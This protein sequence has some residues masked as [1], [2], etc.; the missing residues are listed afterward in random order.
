MSVAKKYLSIQP[1]NVPASGKVSFARGNPI[2]T[3]TLGRQDGVLDLSSLRL[4]GDLNIWRNAAGTLP[5]TGASAADGDQLR[6]SHKLGIYG[7]IDQLVFRHAETKQLLEHIRHYG[8]FMSSYLPVMAGMQDVAGHLSKTALIYPNYQSFRDAVIRRPDDATTTPNEFCIHLPSGL[9]LGESSIPLSKIPLEIEIHLVPDS[10]FFYSS[11]GNTGNIANCF[12]ELS[13]LEVNCEVTYG[14]QTPDKGLLSFNS[15][16]SYFSTIETTNSIINFN[17][18][19]KNVLGAFV[20]FVPSSFINNL[21]QDGYLT[22]MP[23]LAPNAAGTGD[24][25]VANLETISFLRNGERFPS[26]FEV[27]SVRS[28]SNETPVVD[29]QVIKNFLSAIIPEKMH[30]RTTASPLNTNRNYTVNNNADTGY[31]FMPD[32]GALYGVGQ[33]YDQL[34]SQGVDFSNS[35]FSI[36]MINGLNDGNPIS[37]YLFIKSKVVVAWDAQMGIQVIQ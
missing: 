3:I 33:L 35:Q 7:V 22:Y 16:T 23:S 18:G 4:S 21:G 11:D 5:P 12:Y 6:A 28:S 36:Q 20:N 25:N 31:R 8:R 10:Q 9:T 34:D 15:I 17:L 24:G 37:A 2:L 14:Q 13:N 19:L 26:A 1:N 30:T 32:T 29:S 27:E